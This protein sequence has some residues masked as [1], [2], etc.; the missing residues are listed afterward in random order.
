MISL[1]FK[2]QY[3]QIMRLYLTERITPGYMVKSAIQLLNDLHT[4]YIRT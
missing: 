3:I 4:Q 2:V 1:Q